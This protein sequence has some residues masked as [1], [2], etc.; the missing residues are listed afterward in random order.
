MTGR[1]QS[2][3]DLEASPRLNRVRCLTKHGTREM[4]VPHR[5]SWLMCGGHCVRVPPRPPSTPPSFSQRV[6]SRLNTHNWY[7]Q[8]RISHHAWSRHEGSGGG[9]GGGGGRGG[10]RGMGEKEEEGE[11]EEEEPDQFDESQRDR[12][13][14]FFTVG[15][16]H[17]CL[18]AA[19]VAISAGITIFKGSVDTPVVRA[20]DSW[21]KKGRGFQYRQERRENFLLQ[22]QLS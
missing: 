20:P 14:P 13:W 16:R 17:R 1:V 3:R 7:C 9:G 15:I 18:V 22:G 5:F 19:S 10:G 6:Q 8:Y 21:S 11:E 4:C 2:N 12:L